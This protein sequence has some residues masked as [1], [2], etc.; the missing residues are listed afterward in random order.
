MEKHLS[1]TPGSNR[2]MY[3][4][5]DRDRLIGAVY[6]TVAY[7]D[8]FDFPLT[9]PELHR[10]LEGVSISIEELQPVVSQQ[11]PSTFAYTDGYLTFKD[12]TALL[13]QRKKRFAY[14]QSLWPHALRYGRIVASLPYVRMVAVTGSLAMDN[15]DCGGDIDFFVVT[16]PNR[17]WLTRTM[18]IGVV[19]LAAKEGIELCP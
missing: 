11:L 10:Y 4:I 12:R 14:S 1:F 15:A 6:K 17:L 5:L 8:I 13:E 16:E 3:S 18:I 19:R 7:S 9:L 2:D